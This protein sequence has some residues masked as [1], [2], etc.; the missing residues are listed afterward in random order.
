MLIFQLKT[1]CLDTAC[2]IF[3]KEAYYVNL[4]KILKKKKKIKK[5]YTRKITDFQ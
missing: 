5:K 2:T 4:F 3:S 1:N